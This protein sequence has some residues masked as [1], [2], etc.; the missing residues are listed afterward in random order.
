MLYAGMDPVQI[1]KS[2]KGLRE[3]KNESVDELSRA[4][5]ISTSAIGMY[6]A[7]KRVPRD[8]IKIRIAEHFDV[9]VESIFFPNKQ[10]EAC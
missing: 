10:H 6:E 5:N 8:E 3:G 7:G 4:L 2:M 9:S 1:G